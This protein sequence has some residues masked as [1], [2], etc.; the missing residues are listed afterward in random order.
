MFIIVCNRVIQI[1]K[2]GSNFTKHETERKFGKYTENCLKKK[3]FNKT[4][5][6][7]HTHMTDEK[8]VSDVLIDKN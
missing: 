5:F 2:F 7:F 8:R 6:K 3:Q 1:K 4:I